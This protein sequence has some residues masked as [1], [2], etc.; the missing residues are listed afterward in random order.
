MIYMS[1]F[2]SVQPNSSSRI[3]SQRQKMPTG[4]VVGT[5]GLE[6]MS[7]RSMVAQTPLSGVCSPFHANK[8]RALAFGTS[9][10][11]DASFVCPMM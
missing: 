11:G 9:H 3:S 7:V 6:P 4:C 2:E 10:W 1:S 8:L 5:V